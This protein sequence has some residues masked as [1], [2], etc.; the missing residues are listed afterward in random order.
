[1]HGEDNALP[2][3]AHASSHRKDDLFHDMRQRSSESLRQKSSESLPQ[4]SSAL[5]SQRSYGSASSKVSTNRQGCVD[6]FLIFPL[7]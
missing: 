5:L 1:M 6:G 2:D 7:G 3:K 4:K